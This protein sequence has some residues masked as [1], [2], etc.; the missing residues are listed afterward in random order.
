MATMRS[1]GNMLN[2]VTNRY[3]IGGMG[4]HGMKVAKITAKRPPG[5][6]SPWVGIGMSDRKAL[7]G[8]AKDNYPLHN[9]GG[10]YSY[11]RY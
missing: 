9:S 5:P 2:E 11:K 7:M 3:G 1:Y 6:T 4:H 8:G 10:K